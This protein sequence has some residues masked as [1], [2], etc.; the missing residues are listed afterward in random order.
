MGQPRS[1][2]MVG[3][4][5]QPAVGIGDLL[6]TCSLTAKQV[7]SIPM[8]GKKRNPAAVALGRLG[9]KARAKILTAAERSEIAKMGAAA[10]SKRLSSAERKRIA[11]LGVKARQAKRS[12]KQKGDA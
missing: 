1:R 12:K 8:A 5:A 11:M 7:H 2:Q 3:Q 4:T 10:Q 6:Q 9:G